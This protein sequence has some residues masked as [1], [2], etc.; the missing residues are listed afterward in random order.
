MNLGRPDR[1]E[2]P[3][4]TEQRTAGL[5]GGSYARLP[6]CCPSGEKRIVKKSI[7]RGLYF[8]PSETYIVEPLVKTIWCRMV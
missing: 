5:I 2:R 6:Q 7:S 3:G 8:A 1:L 4:S